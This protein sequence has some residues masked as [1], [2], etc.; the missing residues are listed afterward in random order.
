VSFSLSFFLSF[1]SSLLHQ[2]P[3]V[4]LH[5]LFLFSFYLSYLGILLHSSLIHS[6]S[7]LL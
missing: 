4:F 1:C 2:S 6:D 5:E 3:P 7:T